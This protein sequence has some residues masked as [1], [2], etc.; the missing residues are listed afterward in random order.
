M[1]TPL[2]SFQ[3]FVLKTPLGKLIRGNYSL[4]S[5]C[6]WPF[7][8][9]H[10]RTPSRVWLLWLCI[11]AKIKIITNNSIRSW[12]LNPSLCGSR[13]FL[14]KPEGMTLKR[15]FTLHGKMQLAKLPGKRGLLNKVLCGVALLWCPTPYLFTYYFWEKR[16]PFRISSIDKCYP[17]HILGAAS[18]LTA[19]NT[20]SF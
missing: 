16:Y 13:I 3:H 5:K 6:Q 2:F 19:V 20:L 10:Q 14:G 17:F 4:L 15:L 1:F 12:A 7:N 8:A 9:P 11:H 18:L